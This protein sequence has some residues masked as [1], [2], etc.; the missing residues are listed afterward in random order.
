MGFAVRH[1]DQ[2]EAAAADIAGRRMHDRQ[3]ESR[4]N[5]G[6]DGIASGLHDFDTGPGSK[7]MHADHHRMLG[8][9]RMGGRRADR[10]GEQ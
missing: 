10:D 6:V 1:A 3:R 4:G 9:Y 5:G 2:H 7:F 8:T